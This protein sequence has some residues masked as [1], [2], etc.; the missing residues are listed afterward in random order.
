M[1]L[2]EKSKYLKDNV[3]LM[4]EYNYEK[5]KDIDLNNLTL[6]LNKKIWWICPNGHEYYSLIANRAK[7][8]G[9]PYCNGKKVLE[10]YNYLKTYYPHLVNEWDYEKNKGIKPTDVLC[11]SNKKVWWKCSKGHE[12]ES[13]I[14]S[15]TRGDG[16]PY[17]SSRRLLKGYNDFETLNPIAVKDWDYEKNNG[18]L[19]S[20][21]M[22]NSRAKVWW[23]CSR[24]HSYETSIVQRNKS[25]GCPICQSERR[26]SLPEKIVL[27]YI[28]KYFNNVVE[29][30][31]FSNKTKK[32]LDIYIIDNLVAIEYDGSHFH[33][34]I[35]R[36]IEKDRICSDEGIMLYRIR[37][38]G[39]PRLTSSKCYELKDDSNVEL[40]NAIKYILNDLGIYNV[41]INIDADLEN[42]YTLM[43]FSE[44]KQSLNAVNPKIAKELHPTKN[45]N[46]LATNLYAGSN[47]KVWWICP[48]GHE[49]QATVTS[50]IDKNSG[51]PYCAN[52]LVLSG[53]NDLA[54][55]NPK[56]I[57]EW[58]Y[59]KNGDLKPTD[60]VAGSHK[61]VWWICPKGHEYESSLN[62][63][64]DKNSGCPYC[65][66]YLVLSGYNDLATTNPKLTEEWNYEKNGDLKPTDVIAGS[67]KK[68][69]WICPKGHE[70]QASILNRNNG[71]NC[72][73]CSGR[74][75]LNNNNLKDNNPKLML[76]WNY[77]KNILDPSTLASSSREKVW[78]VC[79]KG[80]E[81]EAVISNRVRGSNCPY[82]SGR[83][84]LVGVNDLKTKN[85]K[86]A[87][88][89][90]YEK[91]GDLK[92]DMVKS[93]SHKLVWWKCRNGHEWE[94]TV[95]NRARGR[96]CPI[97]AGKKIEKR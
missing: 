72:P 58:N 43:E 35:K 6:G 15:R 69:W 56:L 54:T 75:R 22:P 52:Y 96:G 70:Y 10:G 2:L 48:N 59:E 74:S 29:N 24:G 28:K 83:L 23:K 73:Y 78:W 65:A 71:T 87:S 20:D 45:G 47:K 92:P 85:P 27:F 86:L 64:T 94:S 44:K 12:W 41:E 77:K 8:N 39:C 80:H 19:P 90:N 26:T 51:C 1:I 25:K 17:C 88:E 11:G 50:R 49:Y 31:K 46:I 3:K 66:N 13:S 57:K 21:V 4:K 14:Y 81:W 5:N 40:A 60:V 63:R 9:C 7:G 37:E 16:C 38:K 91:N 93:S 76:E 18:L 32:D 95:N 42:I 68:V 84:V 79:D 55:T 82:C 33:Q 34:N 97:C 36:D 30:Y 89:W 67:H 62:S 53:Y 61:K